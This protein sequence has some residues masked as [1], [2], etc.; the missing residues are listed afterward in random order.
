MRIAY[1]TAGAAGM[2][3]GSCLH[4]NALVAALRALGHDALLVPTFTP[5]RTDEPDVSQHRVFLGGISVYLME[6]F[7]PFRHAPRWLHRLL[8]SPLLLRQVNRFAGRTRYEDLG[9]LTVSMLQGEHGHQRREFDTLV[10]WLAHDVRPEVVNLTN[11]LLSGLTEELKRHLNVPVLAT[12]QGDDVF[13]DALAEP[14]RSKALS[15]V[16]RHCRSFDGFIA[17]CR[18]YADLM[19]GYLAVPRDKI[20]VVHPGL[21][22]A[23]YSPPPAAPATDRPFTVGYFARITPEKGLH[24]LADAFAR[25]PDIPGAPPPRL[26]IGGWLGDL[27]RPYLDGIQARLAE[28]GLADRFSYSDCPD[29]ASK[30][31]FLQGLDVLSVPA[32]YREPKGL[33][34]LEALASGV[35]VVQPR[36]GAFPELLDATGGGLLVHPHDPADLAAA[37]HRLR[38]DPALRRDLGRRGR[39]AVHARFHARAM[40][41]ATLDVYRSHLP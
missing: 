1:V 3:C 23:S 25:L 27:H 4:D 34:V 31:H 35:P 13:L 37:L 11:V 15:L 6:K 21:N 24:L 41:E 40:A 28:R 18:D 7:S 16:R 30:L 19:A 29:L 10:R 20:H 33:Y 12:L 9:D 8:D 5:I 26:A 38:L 39:E 32:T 36:H 14:H 22:L 2:F 17:T